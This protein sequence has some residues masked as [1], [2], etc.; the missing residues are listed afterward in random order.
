MIKSMIKSRWKAGNASV[1]ALDLDSRTALRH[2]KEDRH[3]FGN[4]KG[5][6]F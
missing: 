6:G 4:D 1:R 2:F 5:K 3:G